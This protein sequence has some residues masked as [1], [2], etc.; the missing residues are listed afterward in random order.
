MGVARSSG[1]GSSPDS[2]DFRGHTP[3]DVRKGLLQPT[4][5]E[6]HGVGPQISWPR[7]PSVEGRVVAL[8]AGFLHTSSLRPLSP[9]KAGIPGTGAASRRMRVTISWVLPIPGRALE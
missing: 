6:T 5:Q 8:M 9:E 1:A 7:S 3:G 2:S 4:V